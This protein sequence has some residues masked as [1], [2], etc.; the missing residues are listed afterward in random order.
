MLSA[1][2]LT[3]EQPHTLAE[4]LQGRKIFSWRT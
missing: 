3:V 2:I 1:R 4:S